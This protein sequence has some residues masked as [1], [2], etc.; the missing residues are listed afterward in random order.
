MHPSA[1]SSSSLGDGDPHVGDGGH[2]VHAGMSWQAGTC[3]ELGRVWA[4]GFRRECLA[5][6]CH[7]R[8]REMETR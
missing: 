8:D 7:G 5:C 4:V 3:E 1:P 6:R 2:A